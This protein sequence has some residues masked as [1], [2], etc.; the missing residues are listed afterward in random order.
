VRGVET[1]AGIKRS[2]DRA[3]VRQPKASEDVSRI[4][5]L[6]E[7]QL[8]LSAVAEDLDAQE[9]LRRAEVAE[10]AALLHAV[11]ALLQFGRPGAVLDLEALWLLHVELDVLELAIEISV[12]DVDGLEL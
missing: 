3:A 11:E 12:R 2:R 5:T 6:S 10:L 8:T 9:L 1:H 4:T 7:P